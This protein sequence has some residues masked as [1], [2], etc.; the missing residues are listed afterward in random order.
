M[1]EKEQRYLWGVFFPADRADLKPQMGA[2]KQAALSLIKRD[3][4]FQQAAELFQGQVFS[5][6]YQQDFHA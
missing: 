1:C 3:D 5:G 2:E 6:F 4:L